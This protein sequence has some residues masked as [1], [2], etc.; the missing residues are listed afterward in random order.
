MFAKTFLL[1]KFG[2]DYVCDFQMALG[3]LLAGLLCIYINY[4]CDRQRQHFRE[5]N[6]KCITLIMDGERS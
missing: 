2:I 5:K 6:G 3:I 4:D 1:L